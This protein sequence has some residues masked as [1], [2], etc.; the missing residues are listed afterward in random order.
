MDNTNAT[1]TTRRRQWAVALL[2]AALVAALATPAAATPPTTQVF[3]FGGAIEGFADDCGLNLR[4]E[5]S[6]TAT[7][8]TFFNADGSVDRFQDRVR[9][10]N[11]ITNLDTGE[12]LQEGPDSFLQRVLLNPDGPATIEINGLSVLVP[13]GDDLVIDAGRVILQGGEALAIVG[14]HDIR[15]IDPSTTTDPILLNGFCAAFDG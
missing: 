4:W 10:T 3:P 2:G 11:T 5:V 14:R 15:A 7:R 6:G 9:E 8:T 1:D 13:G 12:V